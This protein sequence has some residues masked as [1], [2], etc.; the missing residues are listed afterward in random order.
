MRRV[1]SFKDS[2]RGNAHDDFQRW[3]E[4][5]PNGFFLNR[6]PQSRAMLHRTHCGHV[7]DPAREL[8][9]DWNLTA[10]EKVCAP[11]IPTLEEWA[12]DNYVEVSVCSDCKPS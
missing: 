9:G 3:R 11:T 1:E 2:A 6:K 8:S 5:N 4:K 7:E 10:N 12:E